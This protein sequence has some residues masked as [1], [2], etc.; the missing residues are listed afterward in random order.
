MD[1]EAVAKSY[2]RWAPVYDHT[3]GA[4]THAGRRRAT[5]F[6]NRV[7]GTALEVGVGTGLAL[8]FYAP[9]MQVTGVDFS[10]EMLAKAREKVAEQKLTQVAELR[11]M[12]ARSLA[13]ADESFD[14]VCAMHIMSVVPEPERVLS[15]MARVCRI[16]GHV[17]IVNHFAAE[18]SGALARLERLFAPLSDLLGWHSDFA[19]ARVL[20]DA[21]LHLVEE[22]ALPPL[23][24]M[25]YLRLRRIA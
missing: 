13:F 9:H 12:D 4:M 2:A 16:G 7:G 11:Q 24:L 15:E 19:R 6:A 17:L 14:T 23:G 5:G 22:D 3:F 21:R 8:Q 10:D 18:G 1:I 20:G 25:T